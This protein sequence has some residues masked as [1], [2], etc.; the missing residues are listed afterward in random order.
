M[1]PTS[2]ALCLPWPAML[3]WKRRRRR[4]RAPGRLCRRICNSSKHGPVAAVDAPSVAPSDQRPAGHRSLALL[5]PTPVPGG[6]KLT[7]A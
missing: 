6:P 2:S 1:G 7:L 4:R 5:G 3:P